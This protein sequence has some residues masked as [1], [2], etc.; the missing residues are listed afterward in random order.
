MATTNP[1]ETPGPELLDER[2]LLGIF[3]HPIALIPFGLPLV[4]AAYFVSSH[5]FTRANARNALNWHLTFLGLLLL[6][7]PLA[8]FVWDGFVLPAAVVV[9]V[10]G[11]LTWLFCIVATAKAIFGSAWEYPL[12]P[13]LL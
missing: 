9:L 6:F 8:F 1:T 5:P 13:E 12:A 11:P 3:V 7:L 10:G 4:V 2:S